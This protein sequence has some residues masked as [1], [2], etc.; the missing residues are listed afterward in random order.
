L[1]S[2]GGAIVGVLAAVWAL[3]AVRGSGIQGIA[4][5]SDAKLNPEVLAFALGIS[6]LSALLFGLF[7]AL[8][9]HADRSGSIPCRSG[10]EVPPTRRRAIDPA[11]VLLTAEVALGMVLSDWR[12][13][14][15]AHRAATRARRS[16]V[17]AERMFHDQ[18]RSR[19]G[20]V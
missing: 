20:E 6:I 3:D 17:C 7:P 10:G 8:A 13:I 18:R 12:R 16:R 14:D 2:L 1:L 4:R 19:P 5:L 11:R 15:A 9:S